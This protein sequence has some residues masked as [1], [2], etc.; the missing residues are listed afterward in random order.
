[1]QALPP[2]PTWTVLVSRFGVGF[3]GACT[4]LVVSCSPTTNLTSASPLEQRAL[5]AT[6]AVT[7]PFV[8]AHTAA[9]PGLDGVDYAIVGINDI[10][11]IIGTWSEFHSSPFAF[12]YQTTRGITGLFQSD[13]SAQTV[14]YG[15][16]DKGDIVVGGVGPWGIGIWDWSNQLRSLRN[17]STTVG[18]SCVPSAINDRG[19][20]AGTCGVAGQ[21][22]FL[23][24]VWTTAGTP[25]ALR[26][27]SGAF[28]TQN[29]LGVGLSDS[30]YV[31]G[32]YSDGSGFVLTPA[33][34][35]RLLPKLVLNG[36]AYRVQALDVNNFGQAAGNAL[37]DS[38]SGCTHAVVY[39]PTNAI[40]D[41]GC[42]TADGI[43]DSGIVAATLTDS[44]GTMS[45]PVVWSQSTGLR[46]LPGLEGGAALAAETESTVAMN[47]KRQIIGYITMSTGVTHKV[48]WTLQSGDPSTALAA[49]AMK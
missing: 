4:A 1:M 48:M 15:V 45:E 32:E 49:V 31:S 44:A 5:A 37:N 9:L 8:T 23:A 35:L 22:H 10:A 11:E 33:G 28:V 26:T 38:T 47:H 12:K 27:S 3:A 24:T 36:V 21:S 13:S 46:R 39:L 19:I 41:L 7:L 14:G 25:W 43:N 30:G 20:V 18:S 17:L 34:Q 2:S 29:H 40:V 42:G 16:N 6:S